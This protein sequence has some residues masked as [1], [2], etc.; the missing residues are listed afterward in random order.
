M[1]TLEQVMK[2]FVNKTSARYGGDSYPLGYLMSMVQI[3]A[4]GDMELTDRLIRN[5]RITLEDY[6]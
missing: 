3:V 2:E 5:F 6:K 4:A 1:Q